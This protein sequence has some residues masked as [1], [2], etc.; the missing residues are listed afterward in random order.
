MDLHF[1][2][3]RKEKNVCLLKTSDISR[4]REVQEYSGFHWFNFL[5]SVIGTSSLRRAAQLKKKFPHLEFRDIVSF[6]DKLWVLD[7][8]PW[9]VIK[10][11]AKSSIKADLYYLTSFRTVSRL[12]LIWRLLDSV[13][14]DKL[15]WSGCR[16]VCMLFLYLTAFTER[17]FKY[18]LKE[19]RWEGRVQ[20]HNPG[21]CWAEENGLGESHWSGEWQSIEYCSESACLPLR[22]CVCLIE[23]V[24]LVCWIHGHIPLRS[25]VVQGGFDLFV[26][27]H[28]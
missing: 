9:R 6:H 23:D 12:I 15:M 25:D 7:K 28:T 24:H 3:K 26:S 21:C 2:P 5:N 22:P 20:C 14:T 19:A 27:L 17:E 16:T 13:N 4:W 1:H 18:P 11:D 10:V 8:A